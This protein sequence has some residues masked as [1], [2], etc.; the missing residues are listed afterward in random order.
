M[1]LKFVLHKFSRFKNLQNDSKIC[2]DTIFWHSLAKASL[3]K[4][5]RNFSIFSFFTLYR[6]QLRKKFQKFFNEECHKCC[7]AKLFTKCA[8]T[9]M[10]FKKNLWIKGIVQR[11]LTGAETRLK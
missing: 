5:L 8:L 11:K 7:M 3:L 2:F 6:Y 10:S 9:S 1:L 4:D